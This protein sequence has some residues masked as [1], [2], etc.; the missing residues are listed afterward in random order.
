MQFVGKRGEIFGR[1]QVAEQDREFVAAEPRDDRIAEHGLQMFG[2]IAQQ[3]VARGVA[4]R[5]VDD[6]EIVKVDIDDHQP[7]FVAAPRERLVEL[8]DEQF[9]VGQVGQPVVERDMGDLA[10]ALGDRGDHHVE[11]GTEA[12]DL[13]VRGD[14]D[15]GV[16]T[17][18]QPPR[19]FVERAERPGDRACDPPAEHDDEGKPRPGERDEQPL[20]PRIFAER[21]AERVVEYQP[22][23]NAG[24]QGRQRRDVVEDPFAV[25]AFEHASRGG[26]GECGGKLR[27]A[28]DPRIDVDR[29]EFGEAAHFGGVERLRHDEPADRVGNLDRRCRGEREL[30]A[31][32]DDAVILPAVERVPQIVGRGQR[33]GR[34]SGHCAVE[35]DDECRVAS[36][37]FAQADE[38]AFDRRLVARR[39]RLAKAEIARQ[40]IGRPTHLLRTEGDDFVE[41]AR[42]GGEVA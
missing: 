6:L 2:D 15:R 39:H 17:F 19:R 42:I 41:H 25:T 38:G 1:G 31:D 11:T 8:L 22:R 27:R 20:Q 5:I 3:R 29:S 34:R 24:L 37:A 7:R 14:F 18:A 32:P 30:V 4:K 16:L 36:R 21:L 40:H 23:A 13:V 35:P 28:H 33:R 26:T 12:A 10:L 9:A